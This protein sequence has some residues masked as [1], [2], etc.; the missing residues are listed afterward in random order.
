MLYADQGLIKQAKREGRWQ[1]GVVEAMADVERLYIAVFS[2]LSGQFEP[3]WLPVH[4][5]ACQPGE[6][7]QLEKVEAWSRHRP[8]ST[9]LLLLGNH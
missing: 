2:H 1:C 9:R 7:V 3:P 6:S 4:S 8:H 5:P